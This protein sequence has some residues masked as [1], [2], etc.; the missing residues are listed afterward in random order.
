MTS[1][2]SRGHVAYSDGPGVGWEFYRAPNGALMRAP[3]EAPLD[4]RGYR[5]GGRF[6]CMPRAD[7][8]AQYLLQR[9][10]LEITH[11]AETA[12]SWR[13]LA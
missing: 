9:Y 2:P 11:T 7:G 5:Q 10:G 1:K 8:H 13:D 3:A 4:A 12:P 6:E